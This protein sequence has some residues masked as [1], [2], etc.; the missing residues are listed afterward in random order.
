MKRIIYIVLLLLVCASTQAAKAKKAAEPK[1]RSEQEVVTEQEHRYYFYEAMRLF[2]H[3]QYA[4]ALSLFRHCE[5]LLPDDAATC[6]YLA[7]LYGG[8]HKN[9]TMIQYADKAYKAAPLDYWKMYVNVHKNWGNK[10]DSKLVK[11]ALEKICKQSPNETDAFEFLQEIYMHESNAKMA[12]KMQ[13]ELDRIDG[14]TPYGAIQRYNIYNYIGKKKQAL[15]AIDDY[16][17]YDPNDYYLQVVRGQLY[18][19]NGQMEEALAHYQKIESISPENPYLAKAMSDYYG[20]LKDTSTAARYEMSALENTLSTLDYKLDILEKS[21]WL[22]DDSLKL[23]ALRSLV[24]QYPQ[25]EQSHMALGRYYVQNERREEAMQ[26]LQIVIDINPQNEDT[27]K[28]LY[29][30][31]TEDS[32]ID[33]DAEEAFLK[34]AIAALPDMQEWYGSMAYVQK[35]KGQNDTALYYCKEGLKVQKHKAEIDLMLLCTAGDIFYELGQKDSAYSYY[36]RALVINPNY[37][38]VLNN[39]AY[40]LAESG[41]DLRKAEKMSQICIKQE[42]NSATYLDTYAWILHLQG[43][44]MLAKFYIKQAWNYLNREE[45]EDQTLREHYVAIIGQ[46]PQK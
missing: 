28:M 39:Y 37:A 10:E 12:L 35:Q 14:P 4:E 23:T 7:I 38:P 9:S 32:T 34:K 1:P 16:L 6:H 8:M 15:G 41:G 25:E 33:N 11:Q 18:V 26:T 3:G 31:Q 45:H 44:D 24:E 20:L 40:F 29:L 2:D 5:S 19:E 30:L 17:K 27:W 22:A 13:D 42:P 36:E 46:E 21:P 43:Q